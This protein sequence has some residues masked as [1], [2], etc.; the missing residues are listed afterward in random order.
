M[1]KTL[2]PLAAAFALLLSTAQTARATSDFVTFE[3]GAVRP[4]ALSADGNRLFAA[5]TPGNQLEIFSVG[6]AGEL[7]RTA[8]VS[9][10][11]E[12]V[13]V[14]VRS[15]SEVWVVNQ[16]SDSISIVDVGPSPRVTR[17]LLVGDEPRDIVFAGPG[18]NRAFVTTAHRGQNIGFDPQF[19]TPGVGRADVW[20][21]DA[22]D[23]GASLG[24]TP[25]TIVT[26][27]GDTPRAL[28]ASSDGST[29]YAAV[30]HSGNQTSAVTEGAVCNGGSGAGPCNVG[31]LSMPGG[32]PA[33]NQNLDGVPGPETGLIVKFN[34][35]NSR[36]EDRLGRNWTNGVRFNLPDKDVFAIDATADP[37]EEIA[38]FSGVGTVLFNMVVHPTNGK[39]YVSNTEAVNEVRFEGPGGGGSTVRGHLHEARIT[40]IDGANVVPRHLNSHINYTVVPAPSTVKKASLATPTQVI[41]SSD[42]QTLYVAAF[43]SNEVGIFDTA[44]LDAG[45]F[46]PSPLDHIAIP[47]GLPIGLALHEGHNRLYVLSRFD[48]SISAIDLGTRAEVQRAP[49]HNPEPFPVMDGRRFLYDAQLTSSN[50]EA[51]C[52]SC[53]VFGDN[54]DLA[55][56]LGN[57]D[58]S[59]LVDL[60]P[61]RLG[62][63]INKDFHPLKGP[64][65]TQTLRGMAT[66]GPMHW[67]GDRSGANDPNVNNAF[68]E[69]AGFKRFNPAFDGLIGRG[70]QLT[71]AQMQAFT[72]FILKVLPPPNP[73]RALDN[74]LTPD[75]VAAE[76]FYFNTISDTVFACNGCHTLNPAAG[77][78][79]TDGRMTFE[80]EPQVFKIAH[81]DNVYTKVGMFGMPAVAGG[82]NAHMGDQIRGY[83]VLHDGSV[84]TVFRFLNGGV[85]NFPGGDPQRRQVESFVLAFDTTFKPIVGQQITRNSGNGALVDPR[86][87]LMLQRAAA[88][89]CDV[90]VKG[91]LAGE[92]RGAYRL[93]SGQFRTDRAADSPINEA[94]LRAQAATAGQELTYTAVPPGNGERIGIDRDGDGALDSDERDANTDPSSDLS[95]PMSALTCSSGT[96]LDPVLRITRNDGAAGDERLSLRGVLSLTG[97]PVDPRAN[98]FRFK[99]TDKDGNDLFYRAIERGDPRFKRAPGWTAARNGRRWTYKDRLGSSSG[100]VT[101]IVV[102]RELSSDVYHVSV[103]AKNDAFQVPLAGLPVSVVVVLGGPEEG[104]GGICAEKAFNPDGGAD[105]SCRALGSGSTVV[106]N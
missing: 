63:F 36:W 84:D 18:G 40:V 55:W 89:D 97:L 17:T 67:R 73:N 79:G 61:F 42:G 19:T 29:V 103:R 106:C 80:G 33:P 30:F 8:V 47:G 93:P 58:D 64:M 7:T 96:L 22:T 11:L 71:E 54:D 88:G 59:V 15:S 41:L 85:F 38:S 76:D 74:S 75:Q 2:A 20:V 27:F 25:L 34:P 72:D 14:A 35:A 53:H 46:T 83:G 68:D 5:N 66:H 102:R 82:G 94:A 48:N 39:V 98:G 91:T 56:D 92:P 77:F 21:F 10:G 32:L 12:P 70:S 95:L 99:I 50:G 9:V 23:L 13:A 3:S 87:D 31:G 52:S 60:N 49:L 51:S 6:G 4:L 100:G 37:P 65:T 44:Q 101:K 78:F 28:A 81:L 62:P 45:T 1:P 86:I 43:G 16:L 26:L 104:D 69:E 57:P 24:G 90:I 105:P